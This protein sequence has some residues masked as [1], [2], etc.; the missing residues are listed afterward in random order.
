[1]DQLQHD[2]RTKQMIKDTLYD[3]LYAPALKQFRAR[4]ENIITRNCEIQNTGNRA[5][6]Y[7]GEPYVSVDAVLPIK[8]IRLHNSLYVYMDQYLVELNQLNNHELPYVL[9]FISQTLNASNDI[10][11]YLKVLPEAVHRPL[12]S[13]VAQCPCRTS[14]LTPDTVIDLQ[15]RNQVP[16]NL[17]KQRLVINLLT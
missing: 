16:I 5:F 17:M 8:R 12:S 4:L 2:P 3:F 11:D 13:L 14:K 1:M 10:Q 6:F 9:G 15:I 7:K